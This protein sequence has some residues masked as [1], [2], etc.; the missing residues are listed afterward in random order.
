MKELLVFRHAKSVDASEAPSDHERDLRPKGEKSA[1]AMGALL[2]ERKLVPEL[3]LSSDALRARRTADLCAEQLPSRVDVLALGGL[4]DC[5]PRDYLEL[6]QRQPDVVSRLMVVGHNPTLE[7]L[8]EVLTGSHIDLKTGAVARIALSI[9]SWR[10]IAEDP[11]GELAEV[12][13]A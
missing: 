13:T 7:E 6:I 9:T 3:V 8:V 1:S 12:L 4:Y 11:Q 5:T 2:A 10:E